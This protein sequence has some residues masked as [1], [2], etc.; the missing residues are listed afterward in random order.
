MP[1][2]LSNSSPERNLTANMHIND[3]IMTMTMEEL[4]FFLEALALALGLPLRGE[5]KSSPLGAR[6]LG[7][8]TLKQIIPGV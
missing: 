4:G 7:R 6:R 1:S 5:K 3:V 8:S 2:I